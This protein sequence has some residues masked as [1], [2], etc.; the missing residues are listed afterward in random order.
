[1]AKDIREALTLR[2][3]TG[4]LTKARRAVEENVEYR[5]ITHYIEIALTAQVGKD[6]PPPE[7]GTFEKVN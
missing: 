7:P 2:L 4:L 3:P 6:Y 1:M 5:T